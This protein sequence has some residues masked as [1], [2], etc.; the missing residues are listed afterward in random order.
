MLSVWE[1]IFEQLPVQC[2][3][4]LSRGKITTL[5][6]GSNSPSLEEASEISICDLKFQHWFSSV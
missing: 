1:R 3:S 6:F 2:V 4:F 5:P